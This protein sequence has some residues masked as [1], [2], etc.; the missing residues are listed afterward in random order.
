[1]VFAKANE[2]SQFGRTYTEPERVWRYLNL[3]AK[4]DNSLLM[5]VEMVN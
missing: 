3:K 4:A 5:I 1:M 2:P